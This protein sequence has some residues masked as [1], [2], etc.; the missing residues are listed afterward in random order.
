MREPDPHDPQQVT[1][2]LPSRTTFINSTWVRRSPFG[3]YKAPTETTSE[4]NPYRFVHRKLGLSESEFEDKIT[5]DIDKLLQEIE[6]HRRQELLETLPFERV[7][8]Q[9]D[10]LQM[11]AQ[12]GVPTS[13]ALLGVYK[14]ATEQDDPPI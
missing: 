10:C 9:E 3:S 14:W 2:I 5:N 12:S 13:G 11:F 8:S 6:T 1:H 4:P 7:L